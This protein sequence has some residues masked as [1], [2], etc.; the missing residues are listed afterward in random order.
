M[1][2]SLSRRR[3]F[4]IAAPLLQTLILPGLMDHW[5][6]QKPYHTGRESMQCKLGSK[7]RRCRSLGYQNSQDDVLK[8]LVET[9][10]NC[11]AN[12]LPVFDLKALVLRNTEWRLSSFT[13]L[14]K[15]TKKKQVGSEKTK[16]KETYN[17]ISYTVRDHR[18]NSFVTA[19]ERRQ[20]A[21]LVDLFAFPHKVDGGR[22]CD[23]RRWTMDAEG[24][25]NNG[26]EWGHLRG[27]QQCV[28]PATLRPPRH[29]VGAALPPRQDGSRRGAAGCRPVRG[30]SAVAAVVRAAA[31][32]P[33]LR[34]SR[35]QSTVY[36]GQASALVSSPRVRPL[37]PFPS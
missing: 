18:G 36:G 14:E 19:S 20:R 29:S 10:C 23:E 26:E 3:G 17:E 24:Q 34:L 37:G 7:M 1:P 8:I 11:L 4:T 12:R 32:R 15:E 2:C 35:L 31:V 9:I 30:V 33:A 25:H 16:C 27:W 28:P 5:P 6:E 22:R 21:N 13:K